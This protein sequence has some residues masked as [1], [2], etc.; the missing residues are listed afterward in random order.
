V[1]DTLATMGIATNDR[2]ISYSG[3]NTNFILKLIC[4]EIPTPQHVVVADNTQAQEGKQSRIKMKKPR[5]TLDPTG[6]Y[7]IQALLLEQ[8]RG[9]IDHLH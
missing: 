7:S 2:I 6:A 4:V 1:G 8:H 9:R 5:L 3:I